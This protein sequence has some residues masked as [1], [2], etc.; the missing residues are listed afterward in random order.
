MA[1]DL[2]VSV[3]LFFS[4][5]ISLVLDGADKDVSTLVDRYRQITGINVIDI[6]G[7]GLIAEPKSYSRLEFANGMDV[8]GVASQFGTG[9]PIGIYLKKMVRNGWDAEWGPLSR[10]DFYFAPFFAG[11]KMR[12][13]L[14]IE[15]SGA[16]GKIWPQ[17]FY[18]DVADI[19]TRP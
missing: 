6:D 11:E 13:Y 12:E 2:H 18:I 19:S 7:R 14:I 8:K 1:S 9:S 3:G 4:A 17:R 15:P 5:G 16:K 10:L